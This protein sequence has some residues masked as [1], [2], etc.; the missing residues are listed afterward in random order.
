MPCS[1]VRVS[2]VGPVTVT[3]R[4][5][6]RAAPRLPPAPGQGGRPGDRRHPLVR[7]R[8]PVRTGRTRTATG[9]GSSAPSGSGSAPTSMFRCYS[10][11]SAPETDGDLAVTVKRV[12]GGAVS[13]W[14]N[15][16]VSVGDLVDTSPPAGAFCLRRRPASDR[17]LLRGE[18]HHA[19]DVHRQER[20]WPRRPGRS[21]SSTPTGTPDRSSSTGRS[22]GLE[23]DPGAVSVRQA[24]STRQAGSP[25]LEA[26]LESPGATARPTFYVCGPGPFMELV[27]Q[28]LLGLGWRRGHPHRAVRD[29]GPAAAPPDVDR[30]A[31]AGRRPGARDDRR[32][33]SRGERHEIRLPP[34]RHGARDGPPG[35]AARALLV[36]GR[37]VRHLHGPA[38]RRGGDHAGEQR[39]DP[40]GGGEGWVLTCQSVPTSASLADRV[41]GALTAV[42]RRGASG[43]VGST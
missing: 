27:E 28:T 36:R 5:R 14:F 32:S 2:R 15:D 12:P 4:R 22:A 42:A 43:R 29:P 31:R 23:P 1:R 3:E 18:R 6:G 38:S 17:R 30:H 16:H 41:R 9:R 40:R 39:P 24:L 26:V 20:R 35:R 19:G 13:N 37:E 25:T 33:I 11:S 21:A 7:A 8:R 34:R 10:M